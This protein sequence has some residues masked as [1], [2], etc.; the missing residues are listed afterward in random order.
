MSIDLGRHDPRLAGIGL[1]QG[2]G[3]SSNV[4]VIGRHDLT[5]VDAGVGN[6]SNQILPRLARSGATSRLGKV[7]VTH[8]HHDHVGGIFPILKSMSPKVYLHRNDAVY[9]AGYLG[10]DLVKVDDGDIIATELFPL[11]VIHT[12]GHTEGGISLYARKEKMLFSGDTVFPNGLY[13]A[14]YGESGSLEMMVHSLEKLSKLDIEF[15]LPGHDTPVFGNA[16]KHVEL[17]LSRASRR[18]RSS[19]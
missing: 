7:I 3:L 18:L 5:L 13:G 16:N 8:A 2:V 15:M 19:T 1:I 11:E 10:P 9:I 6:D 17:S 12:P 4:Y 14:Y